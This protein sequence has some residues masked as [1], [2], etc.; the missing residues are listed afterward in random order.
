MSQVTE[1]HRIPGCFD[2]VRVLEL[3]DE[4]GEFCGMLM[5]GQGADV[6][7]IEPPEGSPSRR[8]GPFYQ[9]SPGADRSLFF[10]NYN[11]AKRS[12]VLDLDNRESDRACY[13]E[14]VQIADVIVDS[15]GAGVMDRL[16]LG[17][18]FAAHR[19]PDIIYCSI[20]PFG[21]NGPWRDLKASDLIHSALGGMAYCCGY[22]PDKDGR[23]DSPPFNPLGWQSYCVAGEHA[24][25]A[26]A[27]ALLCRQRGGPGQFIDAAIHDACA[28]STEGTVPRYIFNGVDQTRRF[29]SQVRCSDG[30]YLNV[31]GLPP[32]DF[33]KVAELLAHD[34]FTNDAE[35]LAKTDP[36]HFFE[37]SEMVSG[38]AASKPVMQAFQLLQS[39]GVACGPVRYPEELLD[40]LQ[41]VARENFVEIEHPE[42]GHNFLY[43]RHPRRQD[44]TPWRYGPRAPLLG[45]HTEQIR[46][47]L[48]NN[49]QA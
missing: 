33:K 45:E 32:A 5:A 48:A 25:V 39:C 1:H 36:S 43:P 47:E 2:N 16:G 18:E 27:A 3:G 10:W 19:R 42:L 30:A 41:C 38:W 23:W 49:G 35:R 34:G 44:K 17:Y 14:L 20:T 6:I 22:D 26:I 31:L 8:I 37:F 7:K 28:H 9:D 15:L 4:R 21:T 13:G 29:P 11:R 46:K 40:D 24:A 12:I